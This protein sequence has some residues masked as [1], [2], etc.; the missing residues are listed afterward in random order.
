MLSL[1]S[2]SLS[3]GGV[4]FCGGSFVRTF[5]WSFGHCSLGFDFRLPPCKFVMGTRRTK[6]D[7][8]RL[9]PLLQDCPSLGEE[10]SFRPM[11]L[12]EMACSPFV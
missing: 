7:L 3:V 11:G 1:Q 12:D 6:A 8:D 2:F 5:L 9:L 4:R 10:W